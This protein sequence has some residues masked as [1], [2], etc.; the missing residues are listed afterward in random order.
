MIVSDS[1]YLCV[2]KEYISIFIQSRTISKL[3]IS[4]S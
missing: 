2:S 3:Y 4:S 1:K